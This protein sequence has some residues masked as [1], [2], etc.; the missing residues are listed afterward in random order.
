MIEEQ[1][2]G[3]GQSIMASLL[4]T[5]IILAHACLA[6]ENTNALPDIQP[7]FCLDQEAKICCHRPTIALLSWSPSLG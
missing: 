6:A 7:L 1:D 3:T 4:C 2:Q 5:R